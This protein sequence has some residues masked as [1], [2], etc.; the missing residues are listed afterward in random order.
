ML[1]AFQVSYKIEEL[2]R[3]VKIDV[4]IASPI[5]KGE[6]YEIRYTVRLLHH[7]QCTIFPHLHW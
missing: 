2:I 1:T 4:S 3:L 7:N 5:A 6:D